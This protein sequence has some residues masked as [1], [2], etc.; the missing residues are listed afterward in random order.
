MNIGQ[1]TWIDHKRVFP[2][3][4]IQILMTG[5]MKDHVEPIAWTRNHQ[6]A[7]VFYTSLGNVETFEQPAFRRMIANALYWTTDRKPELRVK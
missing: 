4:G 2:T 5:R 6:G 3:K 7:R 1:T